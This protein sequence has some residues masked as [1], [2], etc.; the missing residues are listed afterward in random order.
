MNTKIL[1][2]AGLIAC[3]AL[4]ASCF[5]PWAYYPDVNKTFSGFFSEQNQYGRP[6]KFLVPFTVVVFVFMLL[7]KIW[8]KRA[9]LFICA[10]V[11]GYA[12]KTYVL[13]T[14]CY[15]AYCPEKRIGI[16]VMGLS[17]IVMML[18]AIFPDMKIDNKENTE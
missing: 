17:V 16:Y 4:I 13:F 8:A 3:I 18:A 6:A 1:H 2:Y 7:P 10:L 9:N 15:D 12:I 5:M 11:F 14:S